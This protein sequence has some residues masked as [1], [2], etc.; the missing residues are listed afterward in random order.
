M[1]PGMKKAL[2]DTLIRDIVTS[3]ALV[4]GSR[5]LLSQLCNTLEHS[6][7]LIDESH[8]SVAKL[9]AKRFFEDAPER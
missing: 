3:R 1:I 5:V 6:R 4:N 9:K 8:R 7:R 2:S